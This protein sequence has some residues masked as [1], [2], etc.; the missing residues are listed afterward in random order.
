M[1]VFLLIIAYAV[2]APLIVASLV[3]FLRPHRPDGRL[4]TGAEQAEWT[5]SVGS[6][7][8][9]EV[10]DLPVLVREVADSLASMA[11][12]RY[13][14]INLAVTPGRTM[15]ADPQA[16]R[17]A[18]RETVATALRATSG[19]QVLVSVVPL[20]MGIQIVVTDD[21]TH[22]DQGK[23]EADLRGVSEILAFMGGSAVVEAWPGR[24]T[25]VTLRLPRAAGS[26]GP[27]QAGGSF[28]TKGVRQGG[29][30]TEAAHELPARV[31]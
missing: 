2:A 29:R 21:G 11:W 24:G 6:P 18:L 28:G 1:N 14:R 3:V 15:R 10:L 25:T 12:E 9:S 17:A 27:F 16:L 30:E 8:M 31:A 20:G 5:P 7:M 26:P 23:R 4:E 22:G 19:G 13:T